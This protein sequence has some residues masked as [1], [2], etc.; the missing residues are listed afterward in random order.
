MPRGPQVLKPA[1][2]APR[3]RQAPQ[4]ATQLEA[5]APVADPPSMSEPPA[6][7][8]DPF[9]RFAEDPDIAID[10]FAI[11]GSLTSVALDASPV[12]TE[13][14]IHHPAPADV[15]A[16]AAEPPP[17]IAA[18]LVAPQPDTPP[19]AGSPLGPPPVAWLPLTTNSTVTIGAAVLVVAALGVAAFLG[20][21]RPSAS[22]ERAGVSTAGEATGSAQFES[23][24]SGADVTIDGVLRGKTPLRITLPVGGHALEI[25]GAAGSRAL[26]LT[27]DAGVLVSQYVELTSPPP[28]TGRLEIATEPP[29][30]R[31]GLDGAPKG[32]T[33][34]AL[35]G[36]PIGDHVLTLTSG[37]S[38]IRRIVK[39][40]PGAA[41]SVVASFTDPTTAAASQGRLG[42]KTPFEL[43][44]FE[45]GQLLG[46]ARTDP[47]PL[48]SGRHEL[49]LKND[50][51]EFRSVI[52][53]DIQVGG[54]TSADVM[55]PDGLLSLNALPW[56][57]VLVD[58]RAEGTTPLANLA[59]PIG[60]HEVI[61]R[62]PQLGE[63]RQEVSVPARTPV[64]LSVDFTQ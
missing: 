39:V 49:E 30:A 19:L 52:T 22:S 24:P 18:P 63:R 1:G 44:V 20:L 51:F 45:G 17:L 14:V 25:S 56:A 2:Q 50:E 28:V 13:P 35:D 38:T 47:L 33:P 42:L 6:E 59:I 48:P 9:S 7:S 23:S 58:G 11:E 31:V 37:E 8:A 15:P 61:W 55:L 46:T 26:P 34:V 53:V 40:T 3:K 16:P 10:E 36:V 60:R 43:Q 21:R 57:E 12:D 62:H 41:A 4:G 64:R 29:G 54:L 5:S 27:I 32:L